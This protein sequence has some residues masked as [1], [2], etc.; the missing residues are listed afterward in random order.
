MRFRSFIAGT[1]LA[2]AATA[3]PVHVARG[4]S[5][6]APWPG[7][8]FS[9]VVLARNGTHA[10]ARTSVHGFADAG[11]R[12]PVTADTRFQIG[13]VSKWVTTLAV[14]RLVDRGQLSLDQ[15]IRTYLPALHTDAADKVTLRYLLSNTSGIPDGAMHAFRQNPATARLAMSKAQA[16]LR[17]GN[18]PL[19]FTPGQR[20]DYSVTNWIIVAAIMEKVAGKPFARIIDDELARPLHLEGTGVPAGS[21][22]HAQKAAVAYADAAATAVK[23]GPVPDFAAAS[24]TIYST[25]GD[26]ARLAAA[27]YEGKLLSPD[28]R[29]ALLTVESTEDNYALGGRVR[30]L[31]LGGKPRDVAWESGTIGGFKTLLVHVPGDGKTIVI[32]N[33]TNISQGS[34]ADMAEAMLDKLYDGSGE[35]V[36]RIPAT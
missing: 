12:H 21:F 26:L 25:A 28:S 18:G 29:A 13:S 19:Q 10:P 14:L 11:R 27:T 8:D 22:L 36:P 4:A 2:V 32:L 33:N 35:T 31:K 15:P 24:G 34:Q 7:Q 23:M 30:R 17:F 6:T 16:A 3:V 9:G 20:F 1:L 5:S